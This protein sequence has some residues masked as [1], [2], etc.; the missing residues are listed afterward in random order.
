MKT[1]GWIAMMAAAAV[2]VLHAS[3]TAAPPTA[4]QLEKIKSALPEKAVVPPH[5]PRKLLIFTLCKGFRHSSIECGAETFEMMGQKTGA[6]DT[7]I[8]DDPTMFSPEKLRAFDA[9]CFMN[10]T[11]ELFEEPALKRSLLDFVRSGKGVIGIHAA[12]DC[13]YEWPEYGELMG[14]Y[15]DGHPWGAGDTVTVKIDEPSHP[16]CAPF[17]GKPFEITDEIY[18][19]KAPYSREKLRV[20][21]SLDTSKTDMNKAGIHRDDGDFAVTWIH[22]YGKGRVFYCS[23]GHRE[24]VFWNAAVLKHYLAGIQYAL[25]DLKVDDTPVPGRDAQATQSEEQAARSSQEDG[26][27]SL[28]NGKDLTGWQCKPGS[29]V[30]EDGTLA[31]KGGGDIWTQKPYGDFILELEFKVDPQTNSGVFFRTGDI[32]DCVQTGIEMQVLDSFGKETPD[33]HDCGAIYDCLA[34]R[35]N[36]VR[37][38]GEWNQMTLTCRGSKI[39]VVMNGEE[40][41]DMDL[42]QWTEPHKN[43]DGSGNK[44]NT[45]YKDMSRSGR[46]GFQDHGKPVW[47]RNIRI[48]PLAP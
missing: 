9:V 13:F 4:E 42:D 12:T 36:V 15:F 24:D 19:F 5:S 35:K 46:I 2:L 17:D 22:P 27:V 8:S 6:F 25:G 31:R 34:P 16:L 21:L 3:A 14:A 40:I 26:W 18:Q 33:K 32:N 11:G 30:V 28:F 38:P 20:L 41:I 37:K 10:T 7:V 1:G 44:F 43:P 23:L 39:N 48:K 47:Y 29:W 45:A